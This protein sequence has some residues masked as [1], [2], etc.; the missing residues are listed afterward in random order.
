MAG[1]PWNSPWSDSWRV[2]LLKE[3]RAEGYSAS[4]IAQK[5]G[6]TRNAVIG[7]LT[8]EG[9]A[10]RMRPVHSLPKTRRSKTSCV[11]PT[12]IQNMRNG[13]P[14]PKVIPFVPVSV[15]LK[16]PK[17]KRLTILELTDRT[18]KYTPDDGPNHRFCGHETELGSSWCPYH[19]SILFES[20]TQRDVDKMA[21]AWR[22]PL[23]LSKSIVTGQW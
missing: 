10:D 19:R 8:R 7:R 4:M 18:C 5:L 21:G 15:A 13:K 2:S 6:V 11:S 9:M 22:G 20:R 14:E 1:Q 16:Q 12:I 17:S 3:L 23:G